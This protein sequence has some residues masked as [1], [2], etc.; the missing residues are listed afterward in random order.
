MR[1]ILGSVLVVLVLVAG[2]G[3]C[4]NKDVIPTKIQTPPKEQPKGGYIPD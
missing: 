4:G 1:R 3:G 2:G